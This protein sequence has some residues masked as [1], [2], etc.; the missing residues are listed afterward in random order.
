MP[1]DNPSL[2]ESLDDRAAI[3]ALDTQGQFGMVAALGE[4]VR[5][6]YQA[7]RDVIDESP[8]EVGGVI[9]AGMGGSAIGADLIAAVYDTSMYSTISTVRGYDLPGWADSRTVVFIISY[10]GNTEESL[11]CLNQ[12]LERG[13]RVICIASGGRLAAIAAKQGLDLITVPAGLQ[14]RAAIGHLSIPVAG[15]LESMGLVGDLEEDVRETAATLAQLSEEYGAA[16]PFEANRAKQITAALHGNIPVIYGAELTAVAARRWKGQINENAKNLAF[17]N[18]FP[19]LNHNEIV[20]WEFPGDLQ[21]RFRLVYLEDK[22]MHPQN[23]K[24]MEATAASLPGEVIR[25]ASIGGS[26]L[27][28]VFSSCY[29]G[30]YVS[31]YMAV[32]RGID[33][34]PVDRIEDLK[35]RLA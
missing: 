24:R 20:G 2:A 16:A 1:D 3:A 10:S 18:E 33:P 12:A 5:E 14:P 26:R 11:S 17:F 25:V 15:C 29:L 22:E 7:G 8:H 27:A 28:R 30:D 34:S 19:E 4:Q 32:L 31:L 9:V 6:A 23:V 21:D 35:K 13:C